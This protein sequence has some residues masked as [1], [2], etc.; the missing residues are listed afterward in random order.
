MFFDQIEASAGQNGKIVEAV[1][2]N[3]FGN[4]EAFFAR[5]LDDLVINRMD[6]N[7]DIAS[8]VMTDD[9]FRELTQKH[10]ARKVY[11]SVKR[12]REH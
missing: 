2:T 4:F 10:L 1:F 11:D 6:G 12:Q 3:E 9:T 8:R 7:E 5:I